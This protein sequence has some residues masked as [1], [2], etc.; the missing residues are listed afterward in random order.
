ML[1]SYGS[2]RVIYYWDARAA[3][4]KYSVVPQLVLPVDSGGLGDRRGCDECKSFLKVDNGLLYRI[5]NLK[6]EEVMLY[7]NTGGAQ[8]ARLRGS[9]FRVESCVYAPFR[10]YLDSCV[11][12]VARLIP[13]REKRA[14]KET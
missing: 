12:C 13:G 4:R 8:R 7:T 6:L 5:V 10:L 9:G 11:W 3:R 14:C 2:E 1:E